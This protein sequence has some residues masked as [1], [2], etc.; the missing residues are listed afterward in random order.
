MLTVRLAEALVKLTASW[1]K[2]KS[3]LPGFQFLV[4]LMS[5]AL[6]LFPPFQ[7]SDSGPPLTTSLSVLAVAVLSV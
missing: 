2:K 3:V 6:E 5:H 1:L 7:I 4:V